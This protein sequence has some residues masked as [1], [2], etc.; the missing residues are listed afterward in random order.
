ML[1][2]CKICGTKIDR[3][4]AF[5][6]TKGKS[7]LYYCNEGEYLS[8]QNSKEK[9]Y[10][11]KVKLQSVIEDILGEP[12]TSSSLYK[13]EVD[14]FKVKP[15]DTVIEYLLENKTFISNALEK[16]DFSNQYNKIR[17]FSAI[18]KNNIGTYK[19][20]QPEIIK[21]ASVEIYDNRYKPKP[22]R[23]CLADYEEGE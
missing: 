21:Q 18:V 6:V 15:I 2:T 11:T 22:R 19:L 5:K 10:E 17:Y 13:E 7:N 14:W 12:V 23:K 4:T 1:V 8:Y 9:N 20:P 3:T 16:K